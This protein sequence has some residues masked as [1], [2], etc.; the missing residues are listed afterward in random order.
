VLLNLKKFSPFEIYKQLSQCDEL[1]YV[2][3]KVLA[4]FIKNT[5]NLNT[6]TKEAQQFL[7]SLNCGHRMG[8]QDFLTFLAPCRKPLSEKKL[9]YRSMNTS[10]DQETSS[11]V[12]FAL[13][14]VFDQELRLF[15]E[16]DYLRDCSR[17]SERSLHLLKAF[18]MI[19]YDNRGG[20]TRKQILRFLND[21]LT[22]A[23]ITLSDVDSIYKRLKLPARVI[24]YVDLLN[25]LFPQHMQESPN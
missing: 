2:S 9:L 13:G 5:L 6:T 3:A 21:N 14:E 20:L 24:S 8:Y 16:L 11:S 12:L 18:Q 15:R 10:T 25:A 19:D 7:V 23:Q 4:N 22:S 1:G 17:D